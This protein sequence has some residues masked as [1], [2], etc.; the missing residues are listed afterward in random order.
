ML[1]FLVSDSDYQQRFSSAPLDLQTFSRGMYAFFR[2]RCCVLDGEITHVDD[3]S[4]FPKFLGAVK[5]QRIKP[6]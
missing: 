5:R 6:K 1:P 4:P 3:L 2:R